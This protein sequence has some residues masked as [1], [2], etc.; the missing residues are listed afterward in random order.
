MRTVVV[1]ASSGLGRCIGVALGQRGEQVALLAR[2]KERLDDAAAEAGANGGTRAIAIA[3]DVTDETSCTTA[4]EE[5]ARALGGIDALIYT[6]AIG[7]VAHIENVTAQTWRQAFDTNVI[8]ASLMTS[9]ALPHLVDAHG[10]AVYLSSISASHTPVWPGLGAYITT[11]AALEKLVEAW[12]TEHPEVAFTRIVVGD[13]AGGEGPGMTEFANDWDPALAA[14]F[15]PL[16]LERGLSTLGG[17]LI[18]VEEIVNVVHN[19]VTLG[20]TASI[21]TVVV[22][23]RPAAK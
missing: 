1:G 17:M 11:K 13:T 7:Q 16:W 3:C 18:N 14:E 20:A 4:I 6:P 9:A 10:V 15:A 8:G 23:P 19:I 2:R 5:A 21:P 12:R 22:T